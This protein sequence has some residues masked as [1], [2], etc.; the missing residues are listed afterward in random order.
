MEW[1]SFSASLERLPRRS[2]IL[3]DDCSVPV[4]VLVVAPTVSTGS[5]AS[6]GHV[7]GR[8]G[9]IRGKDKKISYLEAR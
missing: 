6:D 5:Y 2:A 9:I 3:C 7:T 8:V 1:R 4:N